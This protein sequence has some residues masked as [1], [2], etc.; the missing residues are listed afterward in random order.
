MWF[1]LANL[2]AKLSSLTESIVDFDALESLGELIFCE[3]EPIL[4]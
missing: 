2:Y 1:L 4:E 3:I